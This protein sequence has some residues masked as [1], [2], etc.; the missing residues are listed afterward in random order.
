MGLLKDSEQNLNESRLS[1][2]TVPASAAWDESQSERK[3]SYAEVAK[4]LRASGSGSTIE[5]DDTY[6][7]S[8][9]EEGRA[10]EIREP[11]PIFKAADP[12]RLYEIL[13]ETGRG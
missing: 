5:E 10:T 7:E 3:R 4:H 6:V 13:I 9:S 2:S 1:T 12:T 11:V 8:L